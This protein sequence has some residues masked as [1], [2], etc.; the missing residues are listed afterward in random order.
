M[1]HR[2][3]AGEVSATGGAYGRPSGA[4][5]V[6]FLPHERPPVTAVTR[7]ACVAG[8]VGGTAVRARVT[9]TGN[10]SGSARDEC[11]SSASTLR[12]VLVISEGDPGTGHAD[13]GTYHRVDGHCPR[14]PPLPRS[15]FP[16]SPPVRAGR[17][18]QVVLVRV[19]PD[20]R[21]DFSS[22]GKARHRRGRWRPPPRDEPRGPPPGLVAYDGDE[23]VGWISIGPREDYERLPT[24]R[25][26]S[27]S[28]TSRSGRSSASSS[29][30]GPA[31]AGSRRR[32]LMPAS[33]TPATTARRCSRPTPSRSTEG[34]R[35]PSADVYRG[36]LAMFEAPAS[37]GPQGRRDAT[38]PGGPRHRPRT[39][40]GRRP[41]L[42]IT[43]VEPRRNEASSRSPPLLSRD[44]GCELAG[45]IEHEERVGHSRPTRGCG[46]TVRRVNAGR[47]QARDL[48]DER[49]ARSR[50]DQRAA[51]RLDASPEGDPITPD[52][53]RGTSRY[54]AHEAPTKA[55]ALSPRR[56]APSESGIS[57]VRSEIGVRP[58]ASSVRGVNAG[59]YVIRRSPSSTFVH[60]DSASAGG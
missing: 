46:A 48:A 5:N 55:W 49:P 39:S 38:S 16:T 36:T 29:G 4:S 40:S 26:S 10:L 28:T 3:R 1:A 43:P 27:R 58:C 41:A 15:A 50:P 30:A 56:A 22:G 7:G 6:A 45:D 18:P 60:L 12:R 14:H 42:P 8:T 57:S 25:S 34:E 17:R 31:V 11:P 37:P 21:F 35:V 2:P 33:T 19:L 54:P 23:A 32:C 52:D 9:V 20:P 53:Q 59:P 44:H 24:R 47:M 51:P 13:H